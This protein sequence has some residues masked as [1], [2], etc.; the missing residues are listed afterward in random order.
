MK[1]KLLFI[2]ML[3]ETFLFSQNL[4]LN[5]SFE[6]FKECPWKLGMLNNN[7][8]FWSCPNHGSTDYFRACGKS[9]ETYQ[10]YN[11]RQHPFSGAG[12]SGL[13]CYAEKEY[14][15][16]VQGQLKDTLVKDKT[17]EVSFY[18]SLAEASTLSLKNITVIFTAER[19]GKPSSNTSMFSNPNAEE[20]KF[21][22]LSE[23]YINLNELRVKD[24]GIQTVESHTYFEEMES[25]QKISFTYQAKGFE[26]FFTIGNFNANSETEYHQL[27]QDFDH[28]FSYYYIDEISVVENIEFEM[29]KT[30][31]FKDLVFDFDKHDIQDY[32]YPELD[33]LVQYL[34]QHPTSHIEIH[35]HTDN[36]GTDERN[37][38]LS[39]L[40][41]GAV[42]AYLIS[43]EIEA[44]RIIFF[45]HGSSQPKVLNSS[46]TNRAI[47]RRVEFK[48]T[49]P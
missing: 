22:N 4:V 28:A 43:K 38:T 25:W 17:Y 2:F 44:S 21:S 6:E 24:Y 5:P 10:N 1:Y 13:Y 15:E 32:S 3:F 35:G 41:A 11:G 14:R 7:V 18:I 33:R 39:T 34:K 12:Y 30:Y 23:K 19:I 42:A 36:V 16:Y 26:T 40:R 8:Y 31:V 37:K 29:E 9:A 48:F 45:G 49:N 47:N 46:E 20:N 27:K